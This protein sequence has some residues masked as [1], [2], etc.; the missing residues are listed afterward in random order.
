MFGAFTVL[1]LA[2]F[3]QLKVIFSSEILSVSILQFPLNLTFSFKLIFFSQLIF[4]ASQGSLP[5]RELQE[6][7]LVSVIWYLI[8]AIFNYLK[9]IFP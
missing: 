7:S 3:S 9:K 5:S 8:E 2:S 6:N 4:I 1:F